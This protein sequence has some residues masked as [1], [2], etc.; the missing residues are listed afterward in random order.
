MP[1]RVLT[2]KTVEAAKPRRNAAGKPVR[3]E[4]PDSACPGLR[5]VVQPTGSKSWALRYRRPGGRTAKK[6][7]P[8]SLT[9]AGARHAATAAR[10]ELEQGSDP[11]PQRLPFAAYSDTEAIEAAVAAFLELHAYRKTRPR[12]AELYEHVLNDLVLPAWR[13][14]SVE[15]IRRRD[16]ITLV[17]R[18][19]V[20]R[21]V[22]ANR[23]VAVVHKF[24]AWMLSRDMIAASPV[25]GVERPHKEVPRQRTLTE[26]ELVALWRACEGEGPYG[27]AVRLLILTGAR[28]NEVGQMAWDELNLSHCVWLLPA[29][30]SKNKRSHT[31]PL[32]RQAC[33][34]LENPPRFADCGYVFSL[35]GRS[36]I[37]DWDG[38]KKRISAK[39]GID[40]T[41]WGLHD[42]R[43]TVASGLQ[44]LGVA[45]PVIEKAL[46][47][48]SGVFR[49]IAGVYQ[50]HEYQDE[51]RTA[52]QRWADHIERLV[53]G[54]VA[55]KVVKLRRN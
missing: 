15:S 40:A 49:G 45:V 13:G 30:R 5:L 54:K 8:G 26:A 4:Y 12:T 25:V 51:I 44:A 39:A 23:T 10:H 20:D 16:V 22:L 17:E 9:L 24:F 38:A 29:A 46:N 32:S 37:G 14:R 43:R 19:A 2:P 18:I 53:T 33:A 35:Y 50:R 48:A 42:L 47:H 21:P 1:A 6:T 11:A 52:L 28:R 27:A 3:T 55:A 7:W 36:P 41:T 31:L 34:I